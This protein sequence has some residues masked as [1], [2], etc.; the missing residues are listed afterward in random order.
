MSLHTGYLPGMLS[1]VGMMVTA[2]KSELSCAGSCVCFELV[3]LRAHE[4][5]DCATHTL[6]HPQCPTSHSCSN[7][8]GRYQNMNLKVGFVTSPILVKRANKYDEDISLL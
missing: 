1:E 7:P 4:S 5:C 8:R 3:S 6:C 2:V